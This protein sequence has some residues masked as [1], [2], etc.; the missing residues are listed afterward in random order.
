MVIIIFIFKI[1]DKKKRKK[2]IG[3]IALFMNESGKFKPWFVFR[4][5]DLKIGLILMRCVCIID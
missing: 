4:E 2:F 3:L 5:I 1:A